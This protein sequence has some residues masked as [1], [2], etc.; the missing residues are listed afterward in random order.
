MNAFEAPL[1][2]QWSADQPDEWS[3]DRLGPKALEAAGR[4]A[5]AREVRAAREEGVDAWAWLPEW[6]DAEA[7][8]DYATQHR[9][10]LVVAGETDREL[11]EGIGVPVDILASPS[12]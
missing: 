4:A 12:T 10:S 1:P 8:A 6:G 3:G 7:V 9:A 2:T 5:V 11:V